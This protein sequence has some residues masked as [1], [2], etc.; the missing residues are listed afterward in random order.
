MIVLMYHYHEHLDIIYA[1]YLAEL[2][3]HVGLRIY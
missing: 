1:F 2:L 3:H